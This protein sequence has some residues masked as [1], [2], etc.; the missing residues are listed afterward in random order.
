LS[1]ALLELYNSNDY[2]HN[3]IRN[4]ESV[5]FYAVR[6]ASKESRL[7]VLPRT[8]CYLTIF[9]ISILYRVVDKVIR[10]GGVAAGMR[11]GRGNRNTLKKPTSVPIYSP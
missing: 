6:V 1:T 3:N 7:L 8:Y 9:L 11:I 4:V 10:E 2:T 5:V